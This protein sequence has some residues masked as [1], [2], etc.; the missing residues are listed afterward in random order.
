VDVIPGVSDLKHLTPL[1]AVCLIFAVLL[2]V[3]MRAFLQHLDTKDRRIAAVVTDTQHVLQQIQKELTA[4]A[5]NA[6]QQSQILQQLTYRVEAKTEAADAAND[7]VF[8]S[9]FQH[10]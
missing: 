2:A 4:L 6:R 7:C 9:D 1:V 3:L 10:G 5:E 8:R